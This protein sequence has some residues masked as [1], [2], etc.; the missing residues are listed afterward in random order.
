MFNY[1]R[2]DIL[3]EISVVTFTL[4]KFIQELFMNNKQYDDKTFCIIIL[5]KK[6]ENKY[7]IL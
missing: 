4:N 7:Y 1:K 3:Y 5:G 6:T 2:E